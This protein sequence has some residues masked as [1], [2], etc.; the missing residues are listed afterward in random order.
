MLL[1]KSLAHSQLSMSNLGKE[2][3]GLFRNGGGRNKT[4][5]AEFLEKPHRTLLIKILWGHLFPERHTG[6]PVRGRLFP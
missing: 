1:S 3:N 5:F 4:P 2:V 6:R